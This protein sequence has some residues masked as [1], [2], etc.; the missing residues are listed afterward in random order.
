MNVLE[1]IV[2]VMVVTII[3]TITLAV[4]SYGA[5]RMRER[6]RPAP[7]LYERLGPLFFER[8]RM[9]PGTPPETGEA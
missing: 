6:R 4:V 7:D 2:L 9:T 5:F 8:V 1:I 3:V